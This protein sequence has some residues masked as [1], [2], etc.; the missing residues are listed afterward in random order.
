MSKVLTKISIAGF[1]QAEIA[2]GLNDFLAEFK[3]RP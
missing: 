3:G 1:K 2:E